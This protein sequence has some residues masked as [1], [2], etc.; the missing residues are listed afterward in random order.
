MESRALSKRKCVMN[1]Y[2]RRCLVL[3]DAFLRSWWTAAREERYGV[4]L[5]LKLVR[6]RFY[7]YFCHELAG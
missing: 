4:P 1:I 3:M 2:R 5:R 6:L 7:L